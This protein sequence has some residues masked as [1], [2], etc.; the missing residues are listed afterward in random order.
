M[1]SKENNN[2]TDHIK[3]EENTQTLKRKYNSYQVPRF[4][5]RRYSSSTSTEDS[6]E[7]FSLSGCSSSSSDEDERRFYSGSNDISSLD[8]CLAEIFSDAQKM[9]EIFS[10]DSDCW[11]KDSTTYQSTQNIEEIPLSTTVT[12]E[13]DV[14]E[15]LFS[16]AIKTEPVDFPSVNA[17]KPVNCVKIKHSNSYSEPVDVEQDKDSPLT[18]LTSRQLSDFSL[19]Q[20]IM[21]DEYTPS[22]NLDTF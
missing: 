8:A 21:N 4:S 1:T 22:M 15:G 17:D 12:S 3:I 13:F 19:L 9:K 6:S 7:W 20:K 18:T 14:F 5:K 10:D 16:K 11:Y 2:S